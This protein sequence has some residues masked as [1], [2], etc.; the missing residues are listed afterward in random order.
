MG[1]GKVGAIVGEMEVAKKETHDRVRHQVDVGRSRE[2]VDH[3]HFRTIELREGIVVGREERGS[4]AHEG[5]KVSAG[6]L[7]VE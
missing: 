5:G 4:E 7:L 2:I 1:E 6:S 3:L